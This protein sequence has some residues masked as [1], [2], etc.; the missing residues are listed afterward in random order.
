MPEERQLMAEQRDIED[1]LGMELDGK[2]NGKSV[3]AD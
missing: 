2:K 1:M 3:K